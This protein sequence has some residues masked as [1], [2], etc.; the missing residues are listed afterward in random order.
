[1]SHLI[2]AKISFGPEMTSYRFGQWDH[3]KDTIAAFKIGDI[4]DLDKKGKRFSF[5]SVIYF[6]PYFSTRDDALWIDNETDT[7]VER[8]LIC[9]QQNMEKCLWESLIFYSF[10][11]LG[12]YH[13]LPLCLYVHASWHCLMNLYEAE[14][15]FIFYFLSA[16]YC[17]IAF[18]HY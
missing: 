12:D 10:R 17:I 7:P 13:K 16:E 14:K 11:K 1:M 8:F 2:L 15:H 9:V 5:V 4:F 18:F 3:V 6:L